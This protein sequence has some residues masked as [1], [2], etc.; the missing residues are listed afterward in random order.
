M[1]SSF[2]EVATEDVSLAKVLLLLWHKSAMPL[3]DSSLA[4][5]P[6]ARFLLMRR[7]HVLLVPALTLPSMEKRLLEELCLLRGEEDWI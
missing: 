7:L 3:F 1:A 2:V 5:I 6:L 4:S